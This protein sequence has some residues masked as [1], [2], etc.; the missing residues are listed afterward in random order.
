MTT[1]RDF[2]TLL[3]SAATATSVAGLLSLP[4]E[5]QATR[6]QRRSIH[7]LALNDPIVETYRD[8]I[9]ILK[10]R[11][12]GATWQSVTAI[13]GT[14]QGFNLCP[15]GNWYFLPWHRAYL[16]MIEQIIRDVTRNPAFAL[17]YWDWTANRSLP[18]HFTEPNYNGRPNALF[19]T[20]R[21]MARDE[22]IPDDISG[23]Q[24]LQE[25]LAERNFEIFGTTR[26]R[27]QN[28]TDPR[29]IRARGASGPLERQAHDNIHGIVGGEGSNGPGL[30]ATSMSALD[31]IFW[32][33]H[34][35]ID[36]IWAVWNQG[37]GQNTTNNLWLNMTFANHFQRS[38]GQTY[39]ATVRGLQEILPL[40]YRYGLGPQA[41][42]RPPSEDVAAI[43]FNA[44]A[45]TRTRSLGAPPPSTRFAAP[46]ARA[47]A[48][49]G[50]TEF[51]VSTNRNI[52]AP[53]VR[54]PAPSAARSIAG[55]TVTATSTGKRVLALISDFSQPDGATTAV[56]VFVNTNSVTSNTPVTEPGFV[57]T[58]GFFGGKHEGHA[59]HAPSSLI[60]DLTKTLRRL[61]AA[62]RPVG[63]DI[64]VQIVPISVARSAKPTPVAPANVEI[65]VV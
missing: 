14:E 52:V 65:I 48:Q 50:V 46:A 12:T 62:G 45:A 51:I 31:P 20:R 11:R 21:Y 17:P 55:T 54:S 6:P 25:I 64:R 7:D 61:E 28:S 29:W 47:A 19:E 24:V 22:T 3:P 16:V 36:R 49:T 56:R 4:A 35:N 5:A 15:H 41:P 42:A 37:G 13:H 1:R 9:R 10:E 39:S 40:G 33:H 57:G 30:M 38:N 18:P 60:V 27:G 34:C 23:D 43:A 32:L 26:A 59:G 63:D 8:G 53:V 58:F 2:L 44:P